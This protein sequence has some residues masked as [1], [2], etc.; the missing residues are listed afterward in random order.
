VQLNVFKIAPALAAACALALGGVARADSR[1]D[2][3]FTYFVEPAPSQQVHVVRPQAD[4]SVDARGLTIRAGYDADIVTGATPRTYGKVD[5]VSSATPFSDVRHAFHAGL[6]YP[7]RVVT[8]SAGYTYAFER[9]YRSHVV[10]ASARVDLL[11]RNTTFALSYAHNF[12]SACDADNHGLPPLERVALDNADHCFRSTPGIVDEPIAIDSY[13]LSWTQV[14]TR[15]LL[16]QLTGSLEVI[17]G[18]QSNP[19]RRVRLFG[20]AAEAQESE[21]LLRQRAAAQ[22]RLRWMLER[23]RTVL[24]ALGRGY[25][26]TW[27]VRSGTAE[28]E[29][30]QYL[31]DRWLLMLRGRFY[32]QTRAFFYRDAGEAASYEAVGPVGQYFTG[33]RELSP[34]RD[35]LLGARVSY[36]RSAGP[37][38]RLARVFTDVD[39]NLKVDAIK[40]EALT[41][42]PPNAPRSDGFLSALVVQL[43]ATLRF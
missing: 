29:V 26:D 43:G 9:D 23:S 15:A 3:R 1:G 40:Y 14:L 12:D 21:P 33:D 6:S 7:I 27:N 34:F 19:Y 36:V 2:V 17:D 20:G 41:P 11:R 8:L 30:Q 10:E 31:G 39:A 16:L 37:G 24:A 42:L 28:L 32:Q 35:W 13:Q 5:A 18:F 4:V 38:G 22:L 25:W